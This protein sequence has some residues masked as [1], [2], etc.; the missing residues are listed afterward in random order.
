V[1]G[2]AQVR[3]VAALAAIL[4]LASGCAGHQGAQ[5]AYE[6]DLE[7]G[8]VA[9]GMGQPEDAIDAYRAALA[10]RPDDPAALEGLARAQL[11]R[12]RPQAALETFTR[13]ENA[14]PGRVAERSTPELH[15]AQLMLAELRLEQGDYAGSLRLLRG[16]RAAEQ[17]SP[18]H[19]TLFV[20]ALVAESGRLQVAGRSQQ[21]AALLEEALGADADSG[22]L[23]YALASTLVERG[24]LDAAISIL[25]DALLRHPDDERLAALMDRALRIRYPRGLPD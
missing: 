7:H 19:D 20:E 8:A 24:R 25:S 1:P 21:A 10:L 4:A 12:G 13:L 17:V 6:L 14:E 23:E 9:L 5:A 16:L 15:E 3:V 11:A 18:R 22:N 2:R